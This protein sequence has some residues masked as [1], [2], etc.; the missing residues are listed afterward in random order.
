MKKTE[1]QK[2]TF[3]LQIRR[4]A[5][6][7]F[8]ASSTPYSASAQ[9]P[10]VSAH[11]VGSVAFYLER[12]AEN[13]FLNHWMQQPKP[14]QIVVQSCNHIGVN[15]LPVERYA[16]ST[17]APVFGGRRMLLAN[18]SV[19]STAFVPPILTRRVFTIIGL[20]ITGRS[21]SASTSVSGYRR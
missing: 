5:P 12:M 3:S 14:D 13:R 20:L 9:I 2:G 11:E 16:A 21:R 15:I 4:N 8:S 1:S 6:S 17:T 19:S 18:A 7:P 10:V